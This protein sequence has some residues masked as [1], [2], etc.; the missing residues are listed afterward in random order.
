M[1]TACGHKSCVTY[2][3]AFA[4]GTPGVTYKQLDT[5]NSRFEVASFNTGYVISFSIYTDSE[6]NSKQ[7]ES[8]VEGTVLHYINDGQA[9]RRPM[10]LSLSISPINQSS[11]MSFSA[12]QSISD[13]ADTCTSELEKLN[14]VCESMVIICDMIKNEGSMI[15]ALHLTAT[16]EQVSPVIISLLCDAITKSSSLE[17]VRIDPYISIENCSVLVNAVM[18]NPKMKVNDTSICINVSAKYTDEAWI[19]QNANSIR[20]SKLVLANATQSFMTQTRVANE[21]A[22][23][24]AERV[25]RAKR[26]AEERVKRE[27]VERANREAE[28]ERER[29]RAMVEAEARERERKREQERRLDQERETRRQVELQREREIK[30]REAE[31]DRQREREV[32][33]LIDNARFSDTVRSKEAFSTEF[34]SLLNQL[35]GAE[36]SIAADAD[37]FLSML[38]SSQQTPSQGYNPPYFNQTPMPMS[39]PMSMPRSMGPA[40]TPVLPTRAVP[41]EP[42]VCPFYDVH[43]CRDFRIQGAECPVHRN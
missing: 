31:R 12:N 18:N 5:R 26:E 15:K 17:W 33:A 30:Q 9:T 23:M 10:L 25:E 35:R 38:K 34:V 4:S 41:K 28:R 14:K 2:D 39:T 8:T 37:N 32:Q 1:A 24:E 43:Q 29:I 21:K 16:S 3:S 22:K 42:E 6:T 27:A 20:Q 7:T 40:P 13:F 36:G 11:T 19:S